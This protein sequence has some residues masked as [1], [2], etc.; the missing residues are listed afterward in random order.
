MAHATRSA[1]SSSSLREQPRV[2]G[3]ERGRERALAEDVLEEVGDSERRVE[4][5][6]R[7]GVAE[8]VGE[9]ALAD[10]ADDAAQQDPRADEKRAPARA[11]AVLRSRRATTASAGNSPVASPTVKS[12]CPAIRSASPC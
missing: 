6:R 1:S 10:D 7:V 8:E 9:D 5:V 11:R 4:G 2:D 3:D 12:L